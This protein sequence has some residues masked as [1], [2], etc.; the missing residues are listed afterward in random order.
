[1]LSAHSHFRNEVHMLTRSLWPRQPA[2]AGVSAHGWL[3][4]WGG[5]G[6]EERVVW[7]HGMCLSSA[8]VVETNVL[9]GSHCLRSSKKCPSAHT[10]THTHTHKTTHTHT[11]WGNICM[12]FNFPDFVQ[13]LELY[14]IKSSSF[15][16]WRHFFESVKTLQY[17]ILMSE[18]IFDFESDFWILK[19]ELITL[20]CMTCFSWTLSQST[21]VLCWNVSSASLRSFPC[22]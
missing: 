3:S 10:H 15:S 20:K 13:R 12:S 9:S 19:P 17:Y 8:E 16:K 7:V 1:M 21:L 2:N 14:F 5:W 4:E 18:Y 22:S 6:G 11:D